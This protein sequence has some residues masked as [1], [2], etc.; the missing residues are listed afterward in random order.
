[1]WFDRPWRVFPPIAP[2]VKTGIINVK[3]KVAPSEP[4]Q[5][6][7]PAM[8]SLPN[9]SFLELMG[10]L[11][12]GD[13]EAARLLYERY[14]HRLV[15][16]ASQRL[17][18]RLGAKVDPESVMQS[19]MQS[20]FDGQNNDEYVIDSWAALYGLLSKVTVR[21]ALNRNRL[22]RQRKRNDRLDAEGNERPAPVTFED[23]QAACSEPGPDQLVELRDL[24]E[25]GLKKLTE[26]DRKIIES[27]LASGS[28]EETAIQFGVSTRTVQRVVKLFREQM[29]ELGLGRD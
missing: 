9:D 5:M 24:I 14:S 21:K 23:F 13:Q 17:D 3:Y 15:T 11:N 26:I 7:Q 29:E 20:F 1:M 25:V 4:F 6:D 2:E 27:F 28:S 16:L 12:R 8:S 19:V 22:H 10:G 18:K